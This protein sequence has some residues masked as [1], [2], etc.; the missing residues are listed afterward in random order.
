MR[1]IPIRPTQQLNS[2]D[3]ELLS[4]LGN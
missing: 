4:R 3:G 1:A 2:F